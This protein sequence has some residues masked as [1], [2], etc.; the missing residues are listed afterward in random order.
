MIGEWVP[1]TSWK[2]FPPIWVL[3]PTRLYFR[4]A[5][6]SEM[7][8]LPNLALWSIVKSLTDALADAL[9]PIDVAAIEVLTS[10]PTPSLRIM[11]DSTFSFAITALNFAPIPTPLTV[12]SGALVYS[13]PGLV[14]WAFTIF[15]P[16]I[17]GLISTSLPDLKATSGILWKF[18]WLNRIRCLFHRGKD[19]Q[20]YL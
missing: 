1:T 5:V 13:V 18:K 3:Y 7:S 19:R 14:I 17:I 4:P 10:Y 6:S 20:F 16:L 9:L 15:P 2:A 11:T 12:K 8:S